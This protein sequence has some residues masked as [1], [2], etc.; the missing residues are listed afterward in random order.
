MTSRRIVRDGGKPHILRMRDTLIDRIRECCRLCICHLLCCIL[1]VLFNVRLDLRIVIAKQN[2]F[3]AYKRQLTFKGGSNVNCHLMG[4]HMFYLFHYERV[5]YIQTARTVVSDSPA[6][7]SCV[8][9]RSIIGAYP[10]NLSVTFLQ[11]GPQ[12]TANVVFPVNFN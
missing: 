2:V 3:Y 5:E 11:M 8:I 4:L 12:I 1:L 10:S 9:M 7:F 6:H